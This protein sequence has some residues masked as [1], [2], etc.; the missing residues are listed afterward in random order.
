[1]EGDTGHLPPAFH[2]CLDRRQRPQR[3]LRGGRSVVPR[4]DR[5]P[6]TGACEKE[7]DRVPR[8]SEAEV[9]FNWPNL[10]YS[11]CQPCT[12]SEPGTSPERFAPIDT[13]ARAA[14][15]A[16][17]WAFF[18]AISQLWFTAT[19]L[20]YRPLTMLRSSDRLRVVTEVSSRHFFFLG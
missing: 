7:R 4:H 17:A 6:R 2:R 14:A 5:R 15:A 16:D 11:T 9:F 12:T 8:H 1:M 3:G 18:G 20:L 13:A 10:A 19:R